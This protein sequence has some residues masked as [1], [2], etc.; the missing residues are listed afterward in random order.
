MRMIIAM[1]LA[2]TMPGAA[3]DAAPPK[4]ISAVPFELMTYKDGGVTGTLGAGCTWSERRGDRGWIVGMTDDRAAVKHR[5]QLIVLKPAPG[6]N[7]LAPF[8]FD[9]WTGGGL[10]I[11]IREVGPATADG[12]TGVSPAM[13]VLTEA[14]RTRSYRGVLSCGS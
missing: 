4:K 10:T 11:V 2:A 14:G 3:S 12:T 7:D 9:R 5:G 8:T 1:A 13:L 6:A